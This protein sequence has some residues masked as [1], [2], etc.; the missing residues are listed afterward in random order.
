MAFDI[1]QKLKIKLFEVC[2][3]V[4]L[5]HN[6]EKE[7]QTDRQTDREQCIDVLLQACNSFMY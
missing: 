3:I 7:R 6:R 4:A 1:K 2:R 5:F